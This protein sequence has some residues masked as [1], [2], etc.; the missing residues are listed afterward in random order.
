MLYTT[1]IIKDKEYRARLSGK[2]CVE[3]EKRLGGNP[4]NVF[5]RV[6]EG[7]EVPSLTVLLTILHASL[8]TYE[9]GISMDDIYDIYDNYIDDGHTMMDLIPLIMDIFKSS[10]FFVE[11]KEQKN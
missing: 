4:L 1:I 10:G 5:T 11:D 8:Q 3:L 9:H 6:A 7:S 2:M